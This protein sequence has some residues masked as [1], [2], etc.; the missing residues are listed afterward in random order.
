MFWNNAK[1]K[2]PRKS[3]P[4]GYLVKLPGDSTDSII[5]Q[6]DETSKRFVVFCYQIG[7]PIQTP[8]DYWAEIPPLD[9]ED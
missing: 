2:M 8:V 4:Y 5:G 3:S 7:K 9:C 1:K 6:F